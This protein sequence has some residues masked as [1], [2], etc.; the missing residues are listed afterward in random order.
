MPMVSNLSSARGGPSTAEISTRRQKSYQV[1]NTR[2]RLRTIEKI[3]KYRE[4]KLKKEFAK[5][6]E[7]MA[8]EKEREIQEKKKEQRMQAYF[9][10]QKQRL[11]EYAMRKHS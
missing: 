1:R 8:A 7:E 9:R 5:L 10:R 2:D 6:E 3:S 4:E 11:A